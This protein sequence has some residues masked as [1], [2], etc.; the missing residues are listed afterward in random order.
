MS[1]KARKALAAALAGA[2]MLAATPA[3]AQTVIMYFNTSHFMVGYAIYGN[4][5]HLCEQSGY[6]TPIA[7]TWEVEGDC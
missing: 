5:G 1:S 4:D 2:A 7:S 6:V 3:A